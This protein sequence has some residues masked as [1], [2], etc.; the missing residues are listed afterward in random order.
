MA[1]AFLE[2]LAPGRVR[3]RSGGSDPAARVNPVVVAAMAEVGIDVSGALPSKYTEADLREADAIVTMGCGEACPAAPGRTVEDWP[4]EDP[5][6]QTLEEV[7]PIREDV[8]RRVEALVARLLPPAGGPS[9][10]SPSRR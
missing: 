4:V 8:R 10:T 1:A 5:A 9:P 2:R 6:G 3:V 7:R